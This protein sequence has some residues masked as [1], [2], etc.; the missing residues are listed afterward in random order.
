MAARQDQTLQIALIVFAIFTV[1]LAGFTYYFAKQAGDT[2]QALAAMQEEKN[3]AQTRANNTQV[4]NEELR[5]LIGFDQFAEYDAV[6]APQSK[7]DLDRMLSTMAEE[8]RNY[9]DGLQLIYEENQQ[10]ATAQAGDKQK[11]KDLETKLAEVEAGHQ[12]QIARLEADKAKIEQAAAAERNQ[13]AQAR[14]ALDAKQKELAA[15]IAEQTKKFDAERANLVAARDTAQEE[16]RKRQQTIDRLIETQAKDEFSFEVADGKVTYVNQANNTVWINLGAADAL[17]QQV[18]FSVY[19]TED[20][21]AGKAEKKGSIEVVR[22]L[23]PHM[24]ECRVTDDDPRAPILPGDHIYSHVWNIGRPQHF[25]L[26]GLIDLDG[27][28]RSDLQLAKDL[29]ELNGGIVD[30]APNPET[31]E[32]EGEISPETRYMVFGERSERT[33]DAPLRKTWD[34]MHSEASAMGVEKISV[35][36]FINQ[37]GYKPQ[38]RSVNLGTNVNS[39]DF[40][41][42]PAPASGDLRPRVDYSAP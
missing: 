19:D 25:A 36:D 29:I 39:R 18:T 23:G 12:A 10:L 11:L 8:K 6:V 20:T 9:R 7:T 16:S 24:A 22:M 2:H 37:M 15:Q 35:T 32:Q 26:T 41:P 3:T 33:N 40:R 27:D 14:G 38:D 42:R 13:F 34:D 21:D 5:K 28:G 31:G 30:A 17:R 4:Q 1:V